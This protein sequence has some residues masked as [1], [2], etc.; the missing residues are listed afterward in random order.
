MAERTK[1]MGASMACI[2]CSH[3]GCFWGPCRSPVDL[4]HH[5]DLRQGQTH[6]RL[7][8]RFMQG[9]KTIPIQ[10]KLAQSLPRVTDKGRRIEWLFLTD[11]NQ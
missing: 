4:Q 8:T 5:L 6:A 11:L 9:H 2:H 1:L 3:L 10:H 7:T